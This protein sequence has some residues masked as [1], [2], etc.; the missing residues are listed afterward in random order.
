MDDD[1]AWFG[2]G[3][4]LALSSLLLGYQVMALLGGQ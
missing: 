2:L 4:A 3:C 1:F